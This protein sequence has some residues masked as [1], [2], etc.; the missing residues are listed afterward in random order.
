MNSSEPDVHDQDHQAEEG[1]QGEG[2]DDE[3]GAFLFLRRP[4]Q[5]LLPHRLAPFSYWSR[6]VPW[7]MSQ[8]RTT[9][10]LSTDSA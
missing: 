9:L 5:G 2:D 7:A 4:S 8:S 6:Q 3:D 1:D 10:M